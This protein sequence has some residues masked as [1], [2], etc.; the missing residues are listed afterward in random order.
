[1]W[2]L[3][4]ARVGILRVGTCIGKWVVICRNLVLELYPERDT[5]SKTERKKRVRA[6]VRVRESAA[7]RECVREGEGER[8]R[9]R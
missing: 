9:V 8:E 5:E 4:C 6:R 1:M 2:F 3:T 7:E